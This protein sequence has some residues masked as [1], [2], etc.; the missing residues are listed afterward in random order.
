MHGAALIA[1]ICESQRAQE[2]K[3]HLKKDSTENHGEQST[4]TAIGA[5]RQV[6]GLMGQILVA[7]V[8]PFC[9]LPDCGAMQ[10]R[11]QHA[12]LTSRILVLE[13]GLAA[14]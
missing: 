12:R 6:A 13:L 8:W 1:D 10:T 2:G 9:S 4:T 5:G 3:E 14:G 7:L 11:K